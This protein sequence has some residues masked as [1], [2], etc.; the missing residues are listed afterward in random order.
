M[1]ITKRQM[2]IINAAILI[3][4]RR[5]Y[6]DLTTKNLAKEIGLTEAALYRHYDSK[7]DLIVGILDYF[8]YL[9]NEVID[10]ICC[11]DS[12]PIGKIKCF[13]MNRYELF[14]NNPDLAKVMFSDELFKNDPRYA[15]HMQRIM[16]KH[17]EVLISQIQQAQEMEIIQ[18]ELDAIDLFRIIIGSMRL[19]VSQWNL[20]AH[21]FD[22]VGEGEHL[23]NTI[24]KIIE[25]K[26]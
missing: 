21:A 2:E 7:H 24:E 26:A 15:Q 20:S 3:I 9:S 19:I 14:M 16:H 13:V 25:V 11:L 12:S 10:V 22:L 17:K 6:K 5:G 4:A 23:W 18:P 1:E 8:E